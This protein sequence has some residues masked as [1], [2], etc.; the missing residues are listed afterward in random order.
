MPR[1]SCTTRMVE[2][3]PHAYG[4]GAADARLQ[5]RAD[6][7]GL[8]RHILVPRRRGAPGRE[9]GAPHVPLA[10][11]HAVHVAARARAQ[12]CCA[13]P[14]AGRAKRL[15]LGKVKGLGAP[16]AGPCPR[17]GA[18]AR[19]AARALIGISSRRGAQARSAARQ[20]PG[21]QQPLPA[22]RQLHQ[23]PL[24]ATLQVHVCHVA[25][26]CRE[27]SLGAGSWRRAA[28]AR[29]HGSLVRPAAC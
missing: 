16:L 1:G 2:Q 22:T 9:R 4:R 12:P 15:W 19:S 27:M 14:D 26:T 8:E 5:V 6:A 28:H 18:Q 25:I 23:Q 7:D 10:A 29:S 13:A 20:R 17:A 11:Q 3:G 21:L 24:P